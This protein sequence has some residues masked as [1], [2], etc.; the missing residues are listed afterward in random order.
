MWHRQLARQEQGQAVQEQE[1][2]AVPAVLVGRLRAARRSAQPR[3]CSELCLQRW[4]PIQGLVADQ[5]SLTI[6]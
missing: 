5:S 3:H 1:A 2:V 4:G 6:S